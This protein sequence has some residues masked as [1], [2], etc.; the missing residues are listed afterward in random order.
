[1]KADRRE[2]DCFFCVIMISERSHQTILLLNR[3]WQN[4]VFLQIIVK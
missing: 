2:V 4:A 1:M 3:M